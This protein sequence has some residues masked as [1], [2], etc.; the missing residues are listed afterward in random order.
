AEIAVDG[1]MLAFAAAV[2]LVAG[3]GCGLAVCVLPGGW[4]R[5]GLPGASRV[6]GGHGARFR[7]VLVVVQVGL[8][9]LL[10]IGAGLL[11]RTVLALDAVDLGYRP[12]NVTAVQLNP[13]F[14]R[15]G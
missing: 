6:T 3:L 1:R 5:S 2:C 10:T 7:Q 11:V 9:M 14:Q 8:A 13:D 12:S 15:Y 4:Y